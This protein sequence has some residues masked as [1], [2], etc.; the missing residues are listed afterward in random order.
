MRSMVQA[1]SKELEFGYKD[2]PLF[3]FLSWDHIIVDELH[4]LL[5]ITD[6]L[7]ELLIADLQRSGTFEQLPAA[8]SQLGIQFSFYVS[9]E[10]VL[11][12]TSLTGVHKKRMLA[13]LPVASFFP[14]DPERGSR[15]EQ[16]WRNFFALYEIYSSSDY[17]YQGVRYTPDVFSQKARQWLQEFTA[18]ST[19]DPDEPSY[20][21]GMY[22]DAAVTPYMHAVIAHVPV[23]MA[24]LEQYNFSLQL[25][26][27]HSLEKK[28]HSQTSDVFRCTL[29]GGCKSSVYRSLLERE[30]VLFFCYHNC[31]KDSC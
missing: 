25:F 29:K 30:L 13:Q 14:D 22:A 21:P 2:K 28:N 31:Q 10:G 7:L 8:F 11:S 16:L 24:F 4:S 17:S 12:W 27:C 9:K 1:L 6:K 20:R 18:P 3:G 19:G 5:R 15:V 23:M 26:S